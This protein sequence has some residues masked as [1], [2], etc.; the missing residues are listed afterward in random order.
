MSEL[1]RRDR[2]IGFITFFLSG[3]C[4][5]SAGIIISILQ[6][7]YNLTYGTTGSLLSFMSAGS[8][9][10][11]FLSGI[12]PR[13]WG[14]RKTVLILTAGYFIGYMLTA[15][16][17]I[18]GVLI[19]AFLMIGMAK[20]CALNRCTVLVGNN[21]EDRSRGL[22]IMHAC[23]A[24]GALLCPFL[25]T[26]LTGID[27][28]M[29]MLGV[30]LC[31]LIFWGVYAYARLP[32]KQTEKEKGAAASSHEFLRSP[33][34]W[35]LAA[36]LFC[37]NGAETS[38]TGWLVTYYRNQE[39]LSGTLSSYTMTVMWS[40]TLI[41]RLLI[42]F[43]VPI[44]NQFKALFLMGCCCTAL[45]AVLVPIHTALPATIALFA[46][47]FAMA[48]VNPMS[49]A[50]LGKQISQESMAF[51]L[52]LG[53]AGAILMPLIIGLVADRAGLQAGMMVNLFPCAG[54]AIFSGIL[55]YR[56]RKKQ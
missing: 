2:N 13:K 32:K 11:S 44:K 48:G 27:L 49:T 39:I 50:C 15:F 25:I 22:Q 36:L 45:Y 52:P 47:A 43:V 28:I 3:I 4:T 26:A 9:S 10:A 16:I 8:M 7:K 23:Y 1:N 51:L 18:P 56:N 53:S 40:A 41:A 35:L 20:G 54:I 42:A 30:A 6:E 12:L 38:V 21:S 37:Q 17:G 29:P 5:I 24:T 14:V 33:I 31:G 19:A 55:W 46:F 34:F